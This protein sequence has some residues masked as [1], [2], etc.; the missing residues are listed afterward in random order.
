M[1]KGEGLIGFLYAIKGILEA[2]VIWVITG[3]AMLAFFLIIIRFIG[4]KFGWLTIGGNSWGSGGKKL[5]GNA[6]FYA[7]FL[8]FLIFSIYSLIALTGSVFGIN[9]GPSGGLNI[10]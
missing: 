9:N 3:F 2:G 5:D 8:L 1:T 6:I 4:N 7:L 10:R